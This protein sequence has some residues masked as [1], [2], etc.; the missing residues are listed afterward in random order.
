MLFYFFAS[1][2]IIVSLVLINI[3]L[4]D[5]VKASFNSISLEIDRLRQEQERHNRI[6]EDLLRQIRDLQKHKPYQL[7]NSSK[8]DENFHC[9]HVR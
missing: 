7:S 5:F 1:T 2:V 8:E 9:H 4:L 3:F 6:T